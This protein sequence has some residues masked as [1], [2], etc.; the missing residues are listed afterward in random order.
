MLLAIL[1]DRFGGLVPM[2]RVMREIGIGWWRLR[3]AIDDR[4]GVEQV[5]RFL[6]AT[7]GT[8]A[9]YMVAIAAQTFANPEALRL[10]RR[11]CMS[12]HVLLGGR[13]VV[14]WEKGRSSRPQRRSFL[15]DKSLSVPNLI[16]RVLALTEPLVPH[17]ASRD[18][19][20]LFLCPHSIDV[21]RFVSMSMIRRPSPSGPNVR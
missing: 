9:P 11:A 8:L 19:D 1:T 2:Q 15:R 12:E 14:T 3:S 6:H 18:R 20:R 5:A 21:T 7:P 4:G 16:D 13:A 17:V 10:M